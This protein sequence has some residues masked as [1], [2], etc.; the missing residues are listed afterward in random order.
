MEKGTGEDKHILEFAN[1][2]YQPSVGKTEFPIGMFSF[3]W[4]ILKMS[5]GRLESSAAVKFQVLTF[6]LL[7]LYYY[8]LLV[9]LKMFRPLENHTFKDPVRPLIVRNFQYSNSRRSR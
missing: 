8:L 5:A 6:Q 2:V 1:S 3:C 4:L 9:D 7:L